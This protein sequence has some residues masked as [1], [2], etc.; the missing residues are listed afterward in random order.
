[1]RC[2]PGSDP[3]RHLA[4]DRHQ[5]G[6]GVVRAREL[7]VGGRLVGRL[8]R[9][10]QLPRVGSLALVP[11]QR[12]PRQ[13]PSHRRGRED[14][15]HDEHQRP[16]PYLPTLSAVRPEPS[17]PFHPGGVAFLS[18]YLVSTLCRGLGTPAKLRQHSRDLGLRVVLHR[19]FRHET[20]AA[21]MAALDCRRL[22]IRAA[23]SLESAAVAAA[24]LCPT[25]S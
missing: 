3:R 14:G 21:R 19:P 1:M 8:P 5:Q 17:Q 4:E 23:D 20:R 25:G 2:E 16:C 15:E 22:G 13:P 10:D 9:E 6:V 7:H 24:S 11:L 12:R 18:T